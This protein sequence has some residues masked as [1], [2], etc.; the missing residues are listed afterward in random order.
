MII[1]IF[2]K[3]NGCSDVEVDR[4][5]VGRDLV[6]PENLV[7]ELLQGHLTRRI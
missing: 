4:E 6:R 5:M 1:E 2:L 7:R 3:K